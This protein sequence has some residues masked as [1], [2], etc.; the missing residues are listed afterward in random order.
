MLKLLKM[1]VQLALKD[2]NYYI[3]GLLLILFAYGL[4][5][6]MDIMHRLLLQLPIFICI[7]TSFENDVN[8]VISK[9]H[10]LIQ[11][12][13]IKRWERVVSK[14]IL[15]VVKF[16]LLAIYIAL[17]L[18]LLDSF[19]FDS[20]EYIETIFKRE[21]FTLWIISLAILIPIMFMH[22]GIGRM[23]ITIIVTN[24]TTA[25]YQIGIE[26]RGGFEFLFQMS[27]FKLLSI[28]VIVIGISIWLSLFVYNS[29][30]LG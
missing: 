16:V 30:D 7:F 5:I 25:M 26:G 21:S 18:K 10:L 2:K 14:Y 20:L 27:N 28:L 24:I 11:S 29:R 3:N 22:F 15:V 6:K 13:P 8:E 4:A 17:I 23:V 12:L 1:D 9:K 19:G